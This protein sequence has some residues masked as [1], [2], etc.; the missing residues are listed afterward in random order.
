ML[1]QV[2][3]LTS[4]FPSNTREYANVKKC[5]TYH[6][7]LWNVLEDCSFVCTDPFCLCEIGCS[8]ST[9]SSVNSLVC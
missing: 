3:G 4:M 8:M 9:K 2:T 5:K 1:S 6:D 7:N